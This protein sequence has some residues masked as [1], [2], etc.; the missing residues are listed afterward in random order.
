VQCSG[1]RDRELLVDDATLASLR[2]VDGIQSVAAV[3]S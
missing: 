3:S 2:N 1:S